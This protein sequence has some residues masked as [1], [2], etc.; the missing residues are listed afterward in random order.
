MYFKYKYKYCIKSK[1]LISSQ[2]NGTVCWYTINRERF[3]GLNFRGFHGFLAYCESFP[4]NFQL[5]VSNKHWW[6]M[7]CENISVKNFIGLKP[8]MFSPANLSTSMVIYLS[9][10]IKVHYVTNAGLS[11]YVSTVYQTPFQSILTLY[12]KKML[13]N[14]VHQYCTVMFM[15]CHSDVCDLKN[16]SDFVIK[17]AVKFSGFAKTILVHCLFKCELVI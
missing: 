11:T 15:V 8:R 14:V 6:P 10:A 7:H 9:E 2:I 16:L 12:V 3:T 5:Q 4:M 13:L 17:Q 1:S